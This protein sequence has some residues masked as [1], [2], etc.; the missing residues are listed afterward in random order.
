MNNAKAAVVRKGRASRNRGKKGAPVPPASAST[1]VYAGVNRYREDLRERSVPDVV[2]QDERI[3]SSVGAALG[4]IPGNAVRIAR[5]DDSE[6]GGAD[7][8]SEAPSTA[9]TKSASTSISTTETETAAL[10]P[11]LC[12]PCTRV[13]AVL[14]LYPLCVRPIN[15][16]KKKKGTSQKLTSEDVG[17]KPV[18]AVAVSDNNNNDNNNTDKNNN[19]GTEDAKG[20]ADTD[21]EELKYEYGGRKRRR[22]G[23]QNSPQSNWSVAMD[24]SNVYATVDRGVETGYIME[25]FPT[26]YWLVSN[27]WRRLASVL[28]DK[29]NG[30]KILQERLKKEEKEDVMAQAHEGYVQHLFKMLREEDRS[31]I[32]QHHASWFPKTRGVGGLRREGGGLRCLHMHLAHWLGGQGDGG[33]FNIIGKWVEEWCLQIEQQEQKIENV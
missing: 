4:Y 8:Q 24:P 20:D 17:V 16:K 7:D 9:T 6:R 31:Y 26:I 12:S 27:R 3:N 33:E 18:V 11:P 30:V 28:E 10:H 13:P 1:L 5:W 29:H 21:A 32:E 23:A 14:L 22:R 15:V 2:G 19:S 25:P